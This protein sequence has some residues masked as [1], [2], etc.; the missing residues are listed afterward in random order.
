MIE[1]V[2][3]IKD[4]YVSEV[5]TPL[6]NMVAIDA[7]A[8]LS[9]FRTLWQ[10]HRY[11]RVPVYERRVDNVVGI[12]YAMELLDYVDQVGGGPLPQLSEV[13]LFGG[14]LWG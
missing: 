4:T 8:P 2:L 3:E 9:E 5:M 13:G 6:V 1:N 11:S 7:A 14:Q 10:R 12:A